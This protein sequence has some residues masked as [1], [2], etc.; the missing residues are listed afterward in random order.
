[1]VEFGVIAMLFFLLLFGIFDFGMLLNDWISVT[2]GA[3]VGARWAAVGACFEPTCA[4]GEKS[5]IEAVMTSAPILAVS[6]QAA[7]I[8]VIDSQVHAAYCRHAVWVAGVLTVTPI[9]VGWAPDGVAC[10]GGTPL[11]DFNDTLTVVVRANVELPVDL[12][13]IPAAQV[14]QSSATVRYEGDFV[15]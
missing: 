3:S 9:S 5:V 6:P 1:M 2:S 12:P 4:G 7:D 8:A 15:Q 14:V 13:G 11:P 10:S